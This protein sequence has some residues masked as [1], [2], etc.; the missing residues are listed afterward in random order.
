MRR[1]KI[2]N[3]LSNSQVH[4]MLVQLQLTAWSEERR[5]FI[6]G[7]PGSNSCW[8]KVAGMAVFTWAMT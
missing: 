8:M 3:V 2:N 7:E 1:C 4:V 5:N 6:T